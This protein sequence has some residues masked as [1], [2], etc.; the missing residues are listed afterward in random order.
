MEMWRVIW[1]IDIEAATAEEAAGEALVIMRDNDP[2]NTA[3]VF[4]C[5]NRKGMTELVDLYATED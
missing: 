2:A 1:E 3:T 5:T 4:S